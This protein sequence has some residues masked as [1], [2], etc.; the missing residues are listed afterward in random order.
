MVY[1][2]L[3]IE[4]GERYDGLATCEPP[5]SGA[6]GWT[7]MRHHDSGKCPSKMT[8]A[9]DRGS[10]AEFRVMSNRTAT[11]PTCPTSQPTD[12]A[13]PMTGDEQLANL[14]VGRA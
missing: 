10:Q 7:P 1:A 13:A 11:T 3:M 2:L 5:G 12:S 6:L 9:L 4:A 14:P 8:Q